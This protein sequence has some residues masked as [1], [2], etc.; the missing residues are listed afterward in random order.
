M[1]RRGSPLGTI[2]GPLVKL[3]TALDTPRA[4]TVAIL[5]RYGEWDQIANLSIDPLHYDDIRG[6]FKFYCDLQA[7]DV[8]RKCADLPTTFSREEA[9][10]TSFYKAEQQCKASNLRLRLVRHALEHGFVPEYMDVRLLEFVQRCKKRIRKILGPLPAELASQARFGPGA[11]FESPSFKVT[12]VTLGDKIQNDVSCT[13]EAI[14]ILR[15]TWEGMAWDRYSDGYRVQSIVPVRGNRFVTVPKNA[16]TFRGICVEPGGN[17]F[18]QLAVGHHIRQALRRV[19]IDLNNGQHRHAQLAREG[20]MTGSWCTIDLESASDTV[21]YELV[22][23]LLPNQWFDLLASL[24]SPF[25]RTEKG[26]VKLEKFSSM[27]NG[28]TFEL[29]TL[30]FTAIAAEASEGLPGVDTFVYGDDIIVANHRYHDVVGALTFFGFTPNKRKSYHTS[31]FRESCGGQYFNGVEIRSYKCEKVPVDP[32]DMFSFHNGLMRFDAYLTRKARLAVVDLLPQPYKGVRGPA[33]MGDVVLW[34]HEQHR[35]SIKQVAP[36]SFRIRTLERIVAVVENYHFRPGV[37]LALALA[38]VSSR[39]YSTRRVTGFTLKWR[40][41]YGV[42]T[43]TLQ[44]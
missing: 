13:E 4:L 39:G 6:R 25:T 41:P 16:K 8:L 42:N 23:L 26:W 14:P 22:K 9:A 40:P 7:T 28:Y 32:P 34:E 18:L 29:E 19:G 43:D 5:L 1:K 12:D 10:R 2:E 38:G 44:R 37:Q 27:G 21:S 30:I 31:A 33:R 3:L 15:H 36:G 11:T 17:V 20:S 35:W 24:R